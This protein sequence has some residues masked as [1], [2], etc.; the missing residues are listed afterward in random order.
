MKYF[1]NIEDV[2]DYYNIE[3]KHPLIDIRRYSD[4][5]KTNSSKIETTVFDFY[6]ISFIKNFNGYLEY[7]NTKFN[8]ENG[9]LYFVEPG[10]K[11]SCTSTKPWEGYQILIHPN[12]YKKYVSEKKISAFSFFSYDVNESLLLTE[13]E[14]NT[15]SLLM[16]QAWSEMNNMEDDFSIPIVLSYINTLL[17]ITERF[18]DRQFSARKTMCNQLASDFYKQLKNYYKNT[19]EFSNKEQPSVLYFANKLNVTPNYLSDVI[20]H[21]SGKS[22]LHNIHEYIIEEAKILLI[23]SSQTV[24]EISYVLGFE[25]PNYFSRLFKKKTTLSP[26]DF[27]KSVKSI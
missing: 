1:E 15:V 6:K 27:R 9:V 19:S 2:N 13:E 24:S 20:K 11:Y 12:I 8:D 22:A 17:V 3:S 4:V 26:S 5:I 23:T 18:Y 10:Q 14:Q 7:G 25:Y 16:E 21:H